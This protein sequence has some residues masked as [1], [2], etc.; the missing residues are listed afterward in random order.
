MKTIQELRDTNDKSRIEA[1]IVNRERKATILIAEASAL[2]AH[3]E[4]NY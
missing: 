3:L 4:K 2:R 1:G